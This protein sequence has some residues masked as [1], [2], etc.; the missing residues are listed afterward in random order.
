ML[1]GNIPKLTK[2]QCRVLDEIIDGGEIQKDFENGK[3]VYTLYKDNGNTEIIRHDTF[4]RLKETEL[5]KLKYHLS[6]DV[7]R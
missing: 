5:I 6:I 1:I 3:Y 2:E 7:E 4:E